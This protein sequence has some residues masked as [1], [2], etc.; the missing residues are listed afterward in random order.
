V[1][2]GLMQAVGDWGVFAL[3]R[4]LFGPRCAVWAVRLKSSLPSKASLSSSSSSSHSRGMGGGGGGGG[5][6]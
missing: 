1:L 2:Q 5:V 4:S 6:V 3:A